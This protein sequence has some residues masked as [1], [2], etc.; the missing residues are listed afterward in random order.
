MDKDIN[1]FI[2]ECNDYDKLDEHIDFLKN[3]N[4]KIDL[5]SNKFLKLDNLKKKKIYKYL[6]SNKEINLIK[7][8]F[9][10]DALSYKDKY[11]LT[12]NEIENITN[13]VEELLE[14]DEILLSS[15]IDPYN[16]TRFSN[17]KNLNKLEI[18]YKKEDITI[19]KY[20]FDYLNNHHKIENLGIYILPKSAS[21]GFQNFRKNIEYLKKKKQFKI[22]L[23]LDD[24]KQNLDSNDL[25]FLNNV[26]E[27][28][29]IQDLSDNK[30][31]NLIYEKQLTMLIY[32]Y[33][34]YKRRNVVLNK[35]SPIQICYQE[36]P[37]IY[38]KLIY[39]YNLIDINLYDSLKKYAK[40]DESKYQFITL[41]KNFIL[42]MPFYFNYFE[43]NEPKF[44]INCIKIGLIAYS[45]K[46]SHELIRLI[47]NIINSNQNIYLTIYGYIDE[48]W[49]NNI[50]NSKQI[51]LDN[52]INSNPYKLLDNIF[53]IDSISYNNHSTA[54]EIIKLKR[55]FI[56][57]LNINKY[58]GCFSYSLIKFLKMEKYFLANNINDYTNLVKLYTHDEN[59]YKRM[60]HKFIKK[61]NQYNV[62]ENNYYVD[63]FSDTLNNFYNNYRQE[64]YL[65]K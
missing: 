24:I 47:K 63:D 51:I 37:V 19:S 31:E 5:D 4:L 22:Y 6:K 23:F 60:Y 58:H 55:P 20:N 62:L 45:P 21:P 48:K 14:N 33:G 42:P 27:I 57:Y 65:E 54:L 43:T 64:N 35:P 36:P 15:N 40:I 39:D 13:D 52:Y 44:N 26:Y 41:K 49:I 3:N 16:F 17:I 12:E 18:I 32:I 1:Y 61:L 38:P 34:L 7:L 46:I 56:G 11:N 10:V 29:Y 53:F 8:D 59:V 9:L 28:N 30:L 25:N 50:F 2:S